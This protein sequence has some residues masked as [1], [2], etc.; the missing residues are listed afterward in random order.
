MNDL[1]YCVLCDG[2]INPGEPY[3]MTEAG[4]AHRFATTC[5]WHKEEALKDSVC[6]FDVN[7]DDL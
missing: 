6:S 4:I 1:Q 7:D 5:G 2:P 3:V